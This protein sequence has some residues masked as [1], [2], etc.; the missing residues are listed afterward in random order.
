MKSHDFLG[1]SS[2]PPAHVNGHK[3]VYVAIHA[4]DPTDRNEIA[5]FA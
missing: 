5:G 3:L 4:Q 1:F 2:Y